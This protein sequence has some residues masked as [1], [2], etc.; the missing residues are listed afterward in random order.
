[1]KNNAI[2]LRNKRNGVKT[3]DKTTL[4]LKTV[5]LKDPRFKVRSEIN[6]WRQNFNPSSIYRCKE[7]QHFPA[8]RIWIWRR[9]IP[10]ASRVAAIWNH[11]NVC[12]FGGKSTRETQFPSV[13]CPDLNRP[14]CPRVV[15][16]G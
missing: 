1:M 6:F 16:L 15:H 8:E 14:G 3:L 7:T 10:L 4:H 5:H 11:G 12:H 13:A 2:R 9:D